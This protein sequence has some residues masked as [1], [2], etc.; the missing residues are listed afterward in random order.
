[1][2]VW[3]EGVPGEP[4]QGHPL[5]FARQE[6]RQERLALIDRLAQF[7]RD[8]LR[9]LA[10]AAPAERQ[11]LARRPG[12]RRGMNLERRAEGVQRT[13]TLEV[14][15]DDAPHAQVVSLSVRAVAEDVR[16]DVPIIAPGQDEAR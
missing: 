15:L 7:Q 3:S 2:V 4:L 10:V 11:G 8:V 5:A 12:R 16:H 14:P 13:L 9:D 1:R 6:Q